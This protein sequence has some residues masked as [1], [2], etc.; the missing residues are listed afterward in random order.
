MRNEQIDFVATDYSVG[1]RRVEETILPL[2]QERKIAFMA[3]FPFDRGRIFK[4]AA[5]TPLPEWA[6]EFDAKTWAQFFSSTSSATRPS[7][8]PARERPSRRTCSTTSAAASAACRTR[9]CGSGWRSSW[10]HSPRHRPRT[11][12]RR[13][14]LSAAILD[15][16]VGEYTTPA[17]AI[18]DLPPRG[19]DAVRE[20]AGQQSGGPSRRALRDPLSGPASASLRVPCSTARER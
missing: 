16:Y 13:V 19:D 2:A 11:A 8:W 17:G 12:A 18:V 14:E 20:A 3:Y 15:R 4:R 5:A 9:R 1:D 10:I 6:A 7:S